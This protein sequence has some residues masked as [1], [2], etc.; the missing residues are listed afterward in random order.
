M[1]IFFD[2]IVSH[3]LEVYYDFP[4]II[5]KNKYKRIRTHQG[6]S[7]GQILHG[8]GSCSGYNYKTATATEIKKAIEFKK[9][10]APVAGN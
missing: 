1:H 10:P 6:F 4:V 7:A 5:A 9:K 2:L 8:S 3:S